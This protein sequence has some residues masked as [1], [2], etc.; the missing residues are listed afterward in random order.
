MCSCRRYTRSRA[1]ER[2]SPRRDARSREVL[3]ALRPAAGWRQLPTA[4]S[5][6]STRGTSRPTH[7][8]PHAVAA[9]PSTGI[10][11]LDEVLVEDST[12]PRGAAQ[13]AAL[14]RRP[15]GARCELCG[16]GEEWRGRRMALI[17]DHING[18]ADDNR[19]ENL[20]IV[21]PNCAATLDTHCG[22]ANRAA[23]RSDS[24]ARCGDAVSRRGHAQP[25]LLL[26][27]V[28][29]RWPSA[30]GRARPGAR[31]VSGRRT[32]S[33]CAEVAADGVERG[34]AAVRRERQRGPQVGAGLRARTRRGI[35][36]S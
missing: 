5:T 28:R 9:S 7:F 34:R 6:G 12:Y 33:W 27:V 23:D 26:A 3:R 18:V 19:L 16:Q 30:A 11:P 32:S 31:R 22:R 10:P 17:L 8:D 25:A 36:V 13:A 35:E 2:S 1:S 24:C 29:M 4:A 14:R 15:Q 20:R 21:C